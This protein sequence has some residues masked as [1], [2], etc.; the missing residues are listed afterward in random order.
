MKKT[1]LII[2]FLAKATISLLAQNQALVK[3]WLVGSIPKNPKSTLR[4]LK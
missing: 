4:I 3:D 2:A 1:I